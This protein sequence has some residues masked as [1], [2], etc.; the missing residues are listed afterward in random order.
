MRVKIYAD[1]TLALCEDVG[2]LPGMVA[3]WL[4][5]IAQRKKI[6]AFADAALLQPSKGSKY[7]VI[8]FSH[9]LGNW[10]SLQL[11][12]LS[13]ALIIIKVGI[14]TCIHHSVVIWPVMVLL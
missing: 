2:Q 14:G 9:G 13:C 8:I 4:A 1:S 6:D 10:H 7:P 12:V 11:F 5:S 3:S